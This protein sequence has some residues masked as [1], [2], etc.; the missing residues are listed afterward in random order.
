MFSNFLLNFNV[1]INY[2][3]HYVPGMWYQHGNVKELFHS[4]LLV[5]LALVIVIS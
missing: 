3:Y 4:V 1:C 5:T 2:K